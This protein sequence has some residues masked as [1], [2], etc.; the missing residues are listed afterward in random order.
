MLYNAGRPSK[1]PDMPLDV[2]YEVSYTIVSADDDMRDGYAFDVYRYSLVHPVDL[3]RVSWANIVAFSQTKP[4][5][6]S[7]YSLSATSAW[8]QGPPPCLE[9]PTEVVYVY[10]RMA[11][12]RVC[13]CCIQDWYPLL[14][15]LLPCLVENSILPASTGPTR[16]STPRQGSQLRISPA[17]LPISRRAR[18][19]DLSPTPVHKT[20]GKDPAFGRGTGREKLWSHKGF[21]GYRCCSSRMYPLTRPST[22]SKPA[23]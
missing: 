3:L 12:V 15:L 14:K 1:L 6:R 18:H 21:C 10:K 11:R 4:R 20:T 19:E 2:L 7:G 22:M 17:D 16:N 8:P 5:G 9:D 13:K 23:C